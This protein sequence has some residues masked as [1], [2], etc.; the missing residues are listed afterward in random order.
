[1]KLE[2]TTFERVALGQWLGGGTPKGDLNFIRVALAILEKLE[3][4][5]DE[6]DMVGYTREGNNIQWREN[7]I[8]ELNFSPQ[9][10]SILRTAVTWQG[11]PVTRQHQA[12]LEKLEAIKIP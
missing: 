10:M 6:K 3:L 5:E 12:M 11:W 8:S 2:L 7:Q 4:S 9:E 1:M